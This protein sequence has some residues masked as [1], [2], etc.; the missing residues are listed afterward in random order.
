MS[1]LDKIYLEITNV[2]NLSCSFCPPTE[3]KGNTLSTR[4]F[5]R[6]I[7]KI[8]GKADRL[9]FHVKGEPLLHPELGTLID[10]AGDSLF[11]VII[12]TNGILLGEKAGQLEAK[13]NLMRLNV[14][15][16]SLSQLSPEK[17][18]STA[19]AIFDAV[20]RLLAANQK[21][22]PRF[23]VSYRLWTKDNAEETAFLLDLIRRRYDLG[24]GSL[25]CVLGGK[26][27]LRIRP[28]IALHTAETFVWPAMDG[29]D[30]GDE[31]FC[32]GLRD[33]AAILSDGTV[34][35][36]CL[37]GNG[38]I[39]LGNIFESE[40]DQII[41]SPRARALYDAFSSRKVAEE[42]CRKCGYRL[43][44]RKAAGGKSLQG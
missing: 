9:Y 37:D 12:T 23:L 35:P 6:I 42:L 17:K 18:T 25:D 41:S 40:W 8:R 43:R 21:I 34:V 20:E 3:R 19:Y 2:C 26:N 5:S 10:I 16:Q 29:T 11:P 38:V 7:A 13:K 30:Y 33:Q 1:R 39:D 15:L 32:H 27:G 22:N 31:G 36:C 44:F 14:S 4:D 28:G 24:E